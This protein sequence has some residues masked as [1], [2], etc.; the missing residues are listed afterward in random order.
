MTLEYNNKTYDVTDESVYNDF[1]IPVTNLGEAVEVVT[2]LDGIRDYTFNL[3]AYVSM[4]AR[5]R[6]IIIDDRGINVKVSL[7]DERR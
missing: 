4:T 5:K 1:M 6:M 7:I 2:E 3:T